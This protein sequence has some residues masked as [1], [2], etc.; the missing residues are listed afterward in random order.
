MLFSADVCSHSNRQTSFC[1]PVTGRAAPEEDCSS[2]QR[3]SS[4]VSVLVARGGLFF[5]SKVQFTCVSLSH[6]RRIVLLLKGTVHL[7]QP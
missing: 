5:S 4:P 2:P 1:H 7:C 3:Y 6:Q